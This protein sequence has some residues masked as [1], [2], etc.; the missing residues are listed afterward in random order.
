MSDESKNVTPAE[1]VEL[2]KAGYSQK[3]I[4]QKFNLAAP[5]LRTILHSEGME[6]HKFR[7][8]DENVTNIII[9]LISNGIRFADIE[10]VCSIS[11]HATRDIVAR[12]N[13]QRASRRAR[14]SNSALALPADYKRK[15]KFLKRYLAGE[16]FCSLCKDYHLS[17][18]EI[19][20][21]FLSITPRQSSKHK[22]ELT[23]KILADAADGFSPTAIARKHTISMAVVRAILREA[24]NAPK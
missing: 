1:I 20:Y 12:H 2:Y 22:R 18:E 21:E 13:L 9:Q 6:T 7:A 10:E 8:L 17:N 15:E 19:I 4:K 14:N 5:T 23:Q 3:D 11:F 16:S 24:N